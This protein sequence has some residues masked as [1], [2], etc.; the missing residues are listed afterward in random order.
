MQIPANSVRRRLGAR[1]FTLI[2]LMLVVALIGIVSML[3][4]PKLNGMYHRSVLNGTARKLFSALMTA[5]AQATATGA[6]HCLVIDRTARNWVVRQDSDSNGTCDST[7]KLVER[8]PSSTSENDAGQSIP[9]YVA[10]GPAAG[11]AASLPVPYNDLEHDRWCA[12]PASGV[13]TCTLWFEADGRIFDSDGND[14]PLGGAVMLYDPTSSGEGIVKIV[15]YV[16]A[17][18]NVRMFDGAM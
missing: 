9:P 3:A 15:A 6:R 5:Q 16:G 11:V 12:P 13:T 10:F 1:G 14:P 17:T 18:G 4:G 2:E 7:D 8:Y